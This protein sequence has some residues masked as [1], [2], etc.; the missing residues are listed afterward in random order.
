[1]EAT[2]NGSTSFIPILLLKNP[3]NGH[4]DPYTICLASNPPSPNL[5]YDPVYVPVLEHNFYTDPILNILDPFLKDGDIQLPTPSFPFGGLIFTSQRAVEAFASALSHISPTA[6][7][8]G[9]DSRILER[10]GR[11]DIPFYAVGP[12]TA[13]SL[14]VIVKE[15]LPECWIRGGDDAGSADILA[16]LILRDYNTSYNELRRREAEE[17]SAETKKKKKPLLFLTGAKHRDIIPVKL[18]SAAPEQRIDVKELIVYAST[19]SNSFASDISTALEH[20]RAAP[21]QWIVIFSPMAGETLLRALSWLDEGSTA[22]HGPEHPCWRD[23]KTHVVSIGPT[24]RD[25]MKMTF[26]FEVD[27]CAGKP[28]PEG[29]RLGIEGFLRRKGLVP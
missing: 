16:D 20:T 6:N 15:Y 9:L 23:R 4:E 28:S 10:L 12:A 17:P 11:L 18:T 5:T 14:E 26:G 2:P 21:M 1:M 8:N 13:L 29:V 27:V 24:T 7:A 3:S 25:Y 19:E 22:I